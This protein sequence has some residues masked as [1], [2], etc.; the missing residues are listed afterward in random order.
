MSKLELEVTYLSLS[1]KSSSFRSCVSRE[2]EESNC[3]NKYV[4]SPELQF[5]FKEKMRSG[6][7]NSN[8]LKVFQEE[9]EAMLSIRPHANILQVL[10]LCF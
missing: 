4:L 10:Y 9:I 5:I 2:L 1:C 7:I 3:S 6:L 8:E